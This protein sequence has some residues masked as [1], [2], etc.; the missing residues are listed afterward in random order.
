MGQQHGALWAF[1]ADFMEE[2]FVGYNLIPAILIV[3]SADEIHKRFRLE[4]VP[5]S[6]CRAHALALEKHGFQFF[7][8]LFLLWQEICFDQLLLDFHVLHAYC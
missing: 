6:I 8:I 5:L 4:L 7:L 3:K 2:V 1:E